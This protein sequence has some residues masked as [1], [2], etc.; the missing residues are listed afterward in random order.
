MGLASAENRSGN[1][2]TEKLPIAIKVLYAPDTPLTRPIME[3]ANRMFAVAKEIQ[4]WARQVSNCSQL[5][6]DTFLPD[7]PPMQK[8]NGVREGSTHIYFVNQSFGPIKIWSFTVPCYSW[9]SNWL[10][11]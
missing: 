6:L 2:E 9:E 10:S 8:L 4:E 7:S 3:K 1:V 5:F 11:M